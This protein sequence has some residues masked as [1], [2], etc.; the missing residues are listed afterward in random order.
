M[1]L[2]VIHVE[3]GF[4]RG[5]GQGRDVGCLARGGIVAG[6]ALAGLRARLLA[7]GPLFPSTPV[8]WVNDKVKLAATEPLKVRGQVERKGGGA[9]KF[10]Y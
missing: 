1:A 9:E 8:A 10:V 7:V 5:D 6:L 3:D 2:H 4:V